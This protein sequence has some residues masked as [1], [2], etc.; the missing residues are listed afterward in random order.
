MEWLRQLVG[1][2]WPAAQLHLF[3]SRATGLALPGSDLDLVILGAT[4]DLKNAAQGFSQYV[5]PLARLF[6][7]EFQG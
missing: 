1:S 7:Y 5:S 6:P 4:P 2:M 3:G